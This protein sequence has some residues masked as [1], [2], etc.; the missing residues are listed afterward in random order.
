MNCVVSDATTLIV[1]S[2]I[3]R[4]DLLCNIWERVFIPQEVWEE[5]NAKPFVS[6]SVL[7]IV[8]VPHDATHNSLLLILDK[9]ESAAI[10]LAHREAL[11]LIIDEKKGRKWAQNI[12]VRV[13]GLMGILLVNLERSCITSDDVRAIIRRCDEVG[14]RISA[15]VKER[16]EM[17]I[18]R[19]E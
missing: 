9:G 14:F 5:I 11:M 8:E 12:G 16:V 3:E 19:Y 15:S 1:L 13:I 2:R 18:K 17:E 7:E 10:A 4:F 6:H